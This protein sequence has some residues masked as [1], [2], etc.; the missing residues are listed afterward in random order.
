MLTNFIF[1]NAEGIKLR[2]AVYIN[3]FHQ[4]GIKL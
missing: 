3:F 1:I 4:L 2:K